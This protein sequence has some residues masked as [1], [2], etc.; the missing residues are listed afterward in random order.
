MHEVH[1]NFDPCNPGQFYACCGLIELFEL[2]G[3]QAFSR[4]ELDRLLPHKALFVV[5]T[6]AGVDAAKMVVALADAKCESV[7]RTIKR[8][9]KRNS[10]DGSDPAAK[11]STAP[12]AVFLQ[13]QRITLDWWMDEF[14]DENSDLKMWA[15]NQSS[16]QIFTKLCRLLPE[17]VDLGMLLETSTMAQGPFGVDPRSAW[18]AL[19]LGYSPNEHKN[20]AVR[21]YP[22][23]E[24][25]AAIGLQGFRPKGNRSTGL[26]YCL[27]LAPLPASVA[28]TASLQP[29]SGLPHA[30]Y[31]F[32]LEERGSYKNFSFAEKIT[33]A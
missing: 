10:A 13:A 18:N 25:L 11:D 20:K 23:V 14:W 12:L 7:P 1:I 26:G 28:R 16:S 19:D 24:I 9:G 31:A 22:V 21:M 33:S 2:K 29:W 30:S 5:A 4:F 32:S 3:A 15:G 6:N 27:W 17:E 8:R